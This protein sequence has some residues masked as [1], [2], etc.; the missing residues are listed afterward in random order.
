[1]SEAAFLLQKGLK[2]VKIDN[3]LK[4]IDDLKESLLKNPPL[5]AGEWKERTK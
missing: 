5:N 3:L 4:V 1:L 2:S